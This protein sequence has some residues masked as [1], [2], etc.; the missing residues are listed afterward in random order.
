MCSLA[1]CDWKLIEAFF[2]KALNVPKQIS[3]SGTWAAS[4]V[5]LCQWSSNTLHRLCS[6]QVRRELGGLVAQGL[7]LLSW[8]LAA[9]KSGM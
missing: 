3:G 5:F 7:V 9:Q 1:P 6:C 4:L 2:C 8:G